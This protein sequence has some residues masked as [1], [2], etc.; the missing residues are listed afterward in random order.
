MRTA[1][2]GNGSGGSSR[3][4]AQ[5]MV[6]DADDHHQQPLSFSKA[7]LLAWGLFV[8]NRRV[9]AGGSKRTQAPDS[10][11]RINVCFLGQFT[12]SDLGG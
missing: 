9:G 10:Q 7:A 3:I 6:V 12:T 4:T 1:V 11:E 5:A 8:R 2:V